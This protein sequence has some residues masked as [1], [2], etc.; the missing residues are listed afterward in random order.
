M[1]EPAKYVLRATFWDEY[2]RV[3]G[4]QLR[5]FAEG[6]LDVEDPALDCAMAEAAWAAAEMNAAIDAIFASTRGKP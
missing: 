6:K 2:E 4:R 5:E 3:M 1:T